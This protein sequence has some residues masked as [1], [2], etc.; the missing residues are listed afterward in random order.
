MSSNQRDAKFDFHVGRLRTALRRA[1]EG[2]ELSGDALNAKI[3][4]LADLQTLRGLS[5]SPLMC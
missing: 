1:L 2:V 4:R 5:L 3:K